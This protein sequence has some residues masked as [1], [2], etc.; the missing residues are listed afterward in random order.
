MIRINRDD[1]MK[2]DNLHYLKSWI[3]EGK[4]KQTNKNTVMLV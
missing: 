2:S 3:P 1:K 4:A